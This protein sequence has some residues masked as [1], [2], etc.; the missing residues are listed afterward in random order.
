[1]EELDFNW[2][3]LSLIFLITLLSKLLKVVIG[4]LYKM[5]SDSTPDLHPVVGVVLLI[6]GGVA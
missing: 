3:L 6:L 2:V 5:V 1:M 4:P